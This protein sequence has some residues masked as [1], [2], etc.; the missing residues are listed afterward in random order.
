VINPEPTCQ[1]LEDTLTL[2]GGPEG[3]EN[4][5][6]LAIAT[7]LMTEQ[8]KEVME[9]VISSVA[10]TTVASMAGTQNLIDLPSVTQL[11]FGVECQ[12]L[13]SLDPITG[14]A[15]HRTKE[16]EKERVFTP[17]LATSDYGWF[18]ADLAWTSYYLYQDEDLQID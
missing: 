14:Q 13:V 15:V 5:A 7:T 18:T 10:G 17:A 9:I 8:R 3:F 4:G 2:D 6:R 16:G 1:R 12:D 11:P